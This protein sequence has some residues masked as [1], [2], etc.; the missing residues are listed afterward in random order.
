[1]EDVKVY[2]RARRAP[3]GQETVLRGA[4]EAAGLGT[5]RM[6]NRS[7]VSHQTI[8]NLRAGIGGVEIRKADAIAKALGMPTVQLF[9]HA[10]EFAGDTL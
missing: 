10:S 4:M 2:V 6:E 3:G 7:G 1:V 9:A 5:R 8:Q